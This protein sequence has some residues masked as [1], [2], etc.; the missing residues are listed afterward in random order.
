MKAHVG[1]ATRGRCFLS[2]LG[3][4]LRSAA[5]VLTYSAK[6]GPMSYF[7]KNVNFLKFFFAFSNVKSLSEY[8]VKILALKFESKK[9]YGKKTK[10]SLCKNAVIWPDLA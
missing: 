8:V 3:I 1:L 4:I 10:F 6:S 5:Y 7:G 2:T 9:S